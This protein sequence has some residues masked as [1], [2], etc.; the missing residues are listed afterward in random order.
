MIVEKSTE[1]IIKKKYDV[2]NN[3][4]PVNSIVLITIQYT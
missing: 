1:L 4:A 3:D 2:N